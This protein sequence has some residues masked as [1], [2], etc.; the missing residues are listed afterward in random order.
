M[1]GKRIENTN[2]K[3][4]EQMF[5]LIWTNVGQYVI[6]RNRIAYHNPDG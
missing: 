4:N 1:E 6:I 5:V 3:L 2:I